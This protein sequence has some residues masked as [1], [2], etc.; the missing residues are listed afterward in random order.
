[1]GDKCENTFKPK[2]KIRQTDREQTAALFLL[3]ATQLG[4]SM[5]DLDLLTVGMVQDLYIEAANDECEYSELA[6]QSDFDNF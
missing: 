6:T 2:K 4:L 1:M 5:S 3:R